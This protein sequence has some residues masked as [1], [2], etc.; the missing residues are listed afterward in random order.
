MIGILVVILAL[1]GT[2]WFI[3]GVL[4][5]GWSLIEIVRQLITGDPTRGE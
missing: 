3:E 2:W 1:A 4:L 5:V